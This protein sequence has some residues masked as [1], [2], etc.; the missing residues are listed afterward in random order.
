MQ[1]KMTLSRGQG[2]RVI[3]KMLKNTILISKF[4]A[5][6]ELKYDFSHGQP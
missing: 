5:P 3:V 2:H 4:Y 6:S 1:V